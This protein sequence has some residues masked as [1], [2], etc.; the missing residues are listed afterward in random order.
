MKKRIFAL[1][2]TLCM[3]LGLM[4]V[5][6]QPVTV[7][8]A[9]VKTVKIG[10]AELN[11]TNK[12]YHNGADGAQGEA[13][14]TEAGANATFDAGTGT[15]TLNNLK[16][17]TDG[18]GIWW[19]YDY[20]GEKAH[21][22]TIVLNNTNEIK[23]TTGS[24]IVGA[25][26]YSNDGPS[27][28]ITG[29]GILNVTGKTSGIW[30]WKNITICDNVSVS[31]IGNEKYGI[32]NNDSSGT[33]TIKD[34]ANVIANGAEY[35]IGY[36]N[37]YF[38]VP[39]IEGGTVTLS[40]TMGAVQVIAGYTGNSP[41]L[42]G[43]PSGCKVTAGE[44]A[45]SSAEWNTKNSLCN[46]K[47]IKIEPTGHTDSWSTSWNMDAT[48]H[49]HECEHYGCNITE[50]SSKDS[51]GAHVYDNDSDT[52]CNTCNYTR[53]LLTPINSVAITI[54]A[55]TGGEELATK[56]AVSTTSVS[57]TNPDITWKNGE[58]PVSG[59]A[60]YNTAYTAYVTLAADSGYAFASGN[61]ATINGESSDNVTNNPDGTITVS[62][63][64][65][66]T[67]TTNLSSITSPQ[68]ITG[69]ANGT[70]KTATALGLPAVVTINTADS[71]SSTATVTWDLD[72][73][74]SGSYNPSVQTA[75]T[76][77]VK[78]TV[79][80]PTGI[81]NT[82][83]VSLNVVIQV[84]VSAASSTGSGS[85]GGSGSNGGSTGGGSS[86][87]GG[88]TGSSSGGSTTTP[89]TDTDK[90][91]GTKTETTTLP[92]GTKVETT[93]KTDET[94]GTT[95]VEEKKTAPDGTVT[96][97]KTETKKDGSTTETTTTVDTAGTAK[98]TI[99]DKDA[100]MGEEYTVTKTVSK[101][102]QVSS[103][104]ATLKTEDIAVTRAKADRAEALANMKN[105]PLRVKV[106]DGKGKL[107]Y[108]VRVNTADVKADT[109]LYVYKYDS[110]TKTY[111]MVESEYQKVSSDAKANIFCDFEKLTAT[112]RYEFV[113]QDRAARIDKKILATVKVKTAQKSVK[114][115]Q[116]TTFQM[117]EK[118]N[119][120]NV[121]S[122]RYASTDQT[123]ATVSE[124]GEITAIGSGTVVI[125]A[126]VTLL[127]GKTKT[128]RM[129]IKVK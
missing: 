94:T 86:S 99:V 30:V 52:T 63:T 89:S 91:S 90:D 40:G 51:Y 5:V 25:S 119:M 76:F 60:G 56:A 57:S 38:N 3:V 128:V 80:L 97:T 109:T 79:T 71:K 34:H 75:Q 124:S 112:Q 92:D 110:K 24:G 73:L 103:A 120:E 81:T 44:N 116:S 10:T 12:Y 59:K 14:T 95:T 46:N 23:N 47:Y 39:V 117:D 37:S 114:E 129:T 8:A 78:G 66:A 87:S 82:N 55:P 125:K 49:W 6:A 28:T 31:A 54:M 85:T 106:V 45:G 15:L 22:L 93:T 58:T 100:V 33:I 18:P 104:L 11:S 9:P 27:L 77:T 20:Q 70:E 107:D 16:I 43:Y 101:D 69:V 13:N 61:I 48:H 105:I 111:N 74:A 17:T 41:D 121:S 67:G 127:N 88:S 4:P 122:I 29:S 72:T 64:F 36:D 113:A 26:G 62:Y 35:G 118:L 102:G 32:C 53:I 84:T 1:L 2:V 42:R 126:T 83:D 123:I 96:E 19:Q 50:A 68:N 21:D 7:Q 98:S 65:N 115:N 108:K